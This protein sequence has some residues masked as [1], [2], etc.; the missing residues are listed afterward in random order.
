VS[1]VYKIIKKESHV[2][3]IRTFDISGTYTLFSYLLSGGKWH[4][5]IEV[6]D[7]SPLVLLLEM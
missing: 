1:I 7:V 3:N 5:D 6:L 2:A 4:N